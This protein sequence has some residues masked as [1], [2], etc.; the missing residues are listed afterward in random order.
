[1]AHAVRTV[2]NTFGDDERAK[3]SASTEI[4][5]R[6]LTAAWLDDPAREELRLVWPVEG[7]AARY[8]LTMRPP[9]EVE[10]AIE[11]H[12]SAEY[13]YPLAETIDPL[14]TECP[15]GED[16]G[17]QW[18]EE[19]V[20]PA[21]RSSGGIFAECDACSRTFDPSK[22][23]AAI[24]NP[25]GGESEQVMGGAAYRF[26]LKVD[27]GKCFVQNAS[28]AFAR[29]LVALVENEF[30]RDFFEVGATY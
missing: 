16:V 17:F 19:E 28:L 2:D 23:S 15:C 26:A 13:V 14:P 5:P 18:D 4:L 27:C 3:L 7:D 22:R 1:M 6:V 10:Y 21:F 12:R 9:G 29:E 25:F 24:T 30:G 8:P 11:I 20:V